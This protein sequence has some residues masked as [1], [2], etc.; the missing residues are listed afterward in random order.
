LSI[1]DSIEDLYQEKLKTPEEIVRQFQNGWSCMTDAVLSAP[2]ALYTALGNRARKGDIHGIT[3]YTF[4][5]IFPV[6]WYEQP[7]KENVQGISWFSGSGARAAAAAGHCDIMP[8]HY[9]DAPALVTDYVEVDAYCITVSPMDKHGYFSTGC[10]ASLSSALK[11]KAKRIYL[12]VNANMPRALTAPI[13]HISEVTALCESSDALIT[14]PPAESDAVSVTIGNLI[15][16][17]VPDG[18]TIQLGIGAIPSEVGKA[19]KTKRNLGIHTEMFIDGMIELLDCGA[20]DNSRKPIHTGRSVATFAFGSKRLYDY[21][22]DNPAIEML[23]VNYVNDPAVI[24]R[25]PNFVSV[26]AALEV[27]FFGQVSAESLGTRHISG[28]GGQVDYVRGAVL[29]KGGKSFIA[30]PSTASDG[31]ISKIAPTLKAGSVVTTGKNEVDHIVTEY[32]IAKLRGQPLSKRV[33]ALISI[34][35]PRFRDELTFAAKKQGII[36]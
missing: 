33:K 20:A 19:L 12:E 10:S 9:S 6:A 21:I 13:I 31:T 4:L 28:S 14:L 15:A 30:F 11:R 26:N 29:S 1:R 35:H 17:E 22:D 18:A 7:F 27:D 32:G 5:D 8:C 3:A 24:A 23:P 2:R 16:A 36:I 25:H 34:A